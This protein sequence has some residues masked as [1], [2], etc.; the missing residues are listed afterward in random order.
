MYNESL[1]IADTV[2]QLREYADRNPK[3]EFELIFV[4]DGSRDNSAE[5]A[6]LAA[7]SDSRVK[8]CSYS[9]NRGKGY[10]VRTGMLAATGEVRLFTDSDLAYGL[11]VI[12][13]FA[14]HLKASG[15]D[16]V[17][18]SR[19]LAADGYAGYTLLRRFMSKIYIKVVAIAAGFRHS[20]SQS[21]IKCFSGEAA[22]A[23]FR[24]CEVDRFAFDLEAL[25]IAEKLGYKV[26]E[27]GVTI[28]NHR[29]S[30]SKV[31]PIKDTLRML[32]DICKIKKR[33]AKIG[34]K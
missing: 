25:I 28:I 5:A 30:Q 6:K 4:N 32:R 16:I 21:G 7:G 26:S 33:T 22:E 20:D 29:E 23:I 11:D 31:S 1:I 34:K 8:I 12:V 3:Y 13:R 24:H 15:S 19:A 18:G 17:I 10:A 14:D 9:E 27:L 2:T